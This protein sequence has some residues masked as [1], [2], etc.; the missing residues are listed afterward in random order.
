VAITSCQERET[1]STEIRSDRISRNDRMRESS[2]ESFRTSC[3][4]VCLSR[5][6]LAR[7]L[8]NDW[9][10]YCWDMVIMINRREEV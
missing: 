5:P 3:E 4:A 9:Y 8:E 6:R 2:L 1:R 10:E 7:E